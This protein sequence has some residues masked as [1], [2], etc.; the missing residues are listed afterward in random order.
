MEK[1]LYVAEFEE[2]VLML[3]TFAEGLWD[4]TPVYK[5]TDIIEALKKDH[6]SFIL[7]DFNIPQ[8]FPIKVLKTIIAEYAEIPVFFAIACL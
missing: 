6:F 7:F 4:I 2:D 1:V 5:N 3:Q 8:I